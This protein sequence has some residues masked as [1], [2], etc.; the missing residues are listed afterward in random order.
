MG[1][2]DGQS[3]TGCIDQPELRAIGRKACCR[4]RSPLPLDKA[5]QRAIGSAQFGRAIIAQ[6]DMQLAIRRYRPGSQGL[7]PWRRIR[8]RQGHRKAGKAE[9]ACS[10]GPCYQ[11]NEKE[12]LRPTCHV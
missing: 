12:A 4:D 7:R 9:G 5:D 1:G 2:I 10:E 3:F 11:Q 8:R 6:T